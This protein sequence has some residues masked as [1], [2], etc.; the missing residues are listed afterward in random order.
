MRDPEACEAAVERVVAEWGGLDVLVNNAGVTRDCALYS[1]E[2]DEW[3]TVVDSNLFGT[4]SMCRAT[5]PRF[6]RQKRGAIVNISSV[7]GIMG[8]R[9]QTNYCASKAGLIGL[10]RALALECAPRNIRVNAV[11]PG[12]IATDMTETLDSRQR[13]H[14]L[15]RIPLGRFGQAEDVARLTHFL[16]SDA[17]SYI[18]GQVFVVDGGLTA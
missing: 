16:V 5:V 17:A 8:V 1:M 6:L 13:E 9:G 12:F 18:T 11:A 7:A 14:A 10:T 4:F 15:A 2:K 3:R